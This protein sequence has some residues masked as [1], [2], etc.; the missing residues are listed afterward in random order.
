MEMPVFVT[1]G[2]NGKAPNAVSCGGGGPRRRIGQLV[3]RD[4]HAAGC[5]FGA[6]EVEPCKCT[7][8]GEEMATRSQDERVDQEHVP[9]DDLAHL[10][11]LFID[12]K[13]LY[14]TLA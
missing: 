13:I 4:H 14:A 11:L 1:S 9:V 12:D 7:A 2:C 3:G 6:D 8:V 5:P 10:R